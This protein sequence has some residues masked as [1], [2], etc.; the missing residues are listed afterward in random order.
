MFYL[1]LILLCTCG[2]I[3]QLALKSRAHKATA[4]NAGVSYSF[5]MFM[6]NDFIT[7]LLT[8]V[9]LATAIM[10]FGPA[11]DPDVLIEKDK[12][13]TFFFDLFKI[14]LKVI[15]QII[16]FTVAATIGYSGIDLALRFY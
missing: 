3:V 4:N 14:P 5:S 16:I 13:F 2:L 7:V 15:Y 6:N 1:K 8:Y 12:A 11:L 10:I 9:I